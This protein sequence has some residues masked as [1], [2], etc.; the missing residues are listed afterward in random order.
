MRGA[1]GQRTAALS[2]GFHRMQQRQAA[3]GHAVG[4]RAAFGGIQANCGHALEDVLRLG[5]AMAYL[6]RKVLAVESVEHAAQGLQRVADDGKAIERA[7]VVEAA[8]GALVIADTGVAVEGDGAQGARLAGHGLQASTHAGDVG[9]THARLHHE[10]PALAG[11][12]DEALEV[13]GIG[14]GHG[15]RPDTSSTTCSP[16]IGS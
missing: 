16:V 2:P 13:A 6:D 4:H 9:E 11:A 10:L 15:Q 1:L 3:V 7:A 5:R 12:F 14:A 8:Q